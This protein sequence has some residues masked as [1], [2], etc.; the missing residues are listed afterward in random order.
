MREIKSSGEL[1]DRHMFASIQ[2][3]EARDFMREVETIWQGLFDVPKAIEDSPV[4][5]SQPSDGYILLSKMVRLL[6]IRSQRR[7]GVV[8]HGDNEMENQRVDKLERFLRAY[9][10][11]HRRITRKDTLRRVGAMTLLRGRGAIQTLYSPQRKAVP[12]RRR[13]LDPLQY[14]PVYGEDGIDWYTI[15][16]WMNKWQLFDYFKGLPEEMQAGMSIPN[17]DDPNLFGQ[18]LI[19]VIEYWDADQCAWMVDGGKEKH[20]IQSYEH[21]YGQVTLQEA[22]LGDMPVE[23]PRWSSMPFLGP[24]VNDIKQKAILESKMATGVEA[25]YYGLIYAQTQD[26]A[27]IRLDPYAPPGAIQNLPAG[28]TI[29]QFKP[30]AD[31]NSLKMLYDVFQGKINKGTLS[32][33]AFALDQSGA[34]GFAQQQVLSILQDD[35]ADFRDQ[36]ESVE[37]ASLGDVLHLHEVFAPDDG[38]EY[39]LEKKGGA[40]KLEMIKADDINGHTR[41]TVGIKVDLP[42]DRLQKAT[43]FNQTY[44]AGPDGKYRID[45][46]TALAFSGMDDDIEDISGMKRRVDWY[47][48]IQNDPELAQLNLARI[49]SEYRGEIEQW[50]KEVDQDARKVQQIEQRSAAQKIDKG[51]SQDVILPADLASDPQKMQQYAGM[52]A[53]GMTPQAAVDTLQQGGQPLGV[54][55]M[56]GQQGQGPQQPPQGPPGPAGQAHPDTMAI[57]Q[58]LFGAN[59]QLAPDAANGMTGYANGIPPTALPAAMQGAQ[60]RPAMDPAQLFLE[61]NQQNQQRGALPAPK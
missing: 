46:D 52:I 53:Q 16:R 40:V 27:I 18:D 55:G 34:S 29:Q 49:K 42:Q 60:P 38:W 61:Q 45:F 12:V 47:W 32:E 41:V 36:L 15:E 13:V 39:P 28:A 44:Q 57:L 17:E 14:S 50:R 3:A 10:S 31:Q 54:P 1:Y 48:A 8:G 22:A 51:L 20:L 37:G 5:I 9:E 35:I 56:P 58:H 19:R 30:T 11:E 24:N 43:I 6:G 33:L 21:G 26:G 2:Y 59:A 25:F 4:E 7:L 23:N